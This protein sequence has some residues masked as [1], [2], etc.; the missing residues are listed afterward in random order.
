[1]G[2]SQPHIQQM[3]SRIT[4]EIFKV[5]LAP[6]GW[7][8]RGFGWAFN[9]PIRRFVHLF[10]AADQAAVHEGI[11]GGCRSLLRDFNL[12]PKVKG[13]ENLEGEGP[14]L[15]AANHPGAYDSACLGAFVPRTDLKL[16]VYET[17]FYHALF[18]IDPY[19]IHTTHDPSRRMQ[20][21][22]QAVRH[23]QTGGSLLT[24]GTGKIEPDPALGN[25]DDIGIADW[26]PAVEIL[27]RKA[28]VGQ[29]RLAEYLQIIWHL[30]FRRAVAVQPLLTFSAPLTLSAL[31]AE[32]D[33]ERLMPLILR[34]AQALQAEH[35]AD[36]G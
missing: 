13:A 36:F 17:S 11:P 23:L 2:G 1:M 33:G 34:K 35:L 25:G 5:G 24:F 7:F 31:E 26:S 6:E 27:L 9:L 14:L 18:N 32:A 19:L 16:I 15:I 28:P 10:A 30:L 12:Q 21:L 8:R 4:D 22:R 29:R 3:Q 20:A